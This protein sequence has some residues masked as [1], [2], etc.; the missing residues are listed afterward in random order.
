MKLV[1]L[2]N[3]GNN[4]QIVVSLKELKDFFHEVSGGR[5]DSGLSD[6]PQYLT[7]K[8]TLL[9]LNIDPSTL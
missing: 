6:Q 2:L 7:R 8:E 3:E 4:V 5:Q 1:E 9:M